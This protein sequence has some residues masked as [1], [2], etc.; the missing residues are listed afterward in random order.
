MVTPRCRV[1]MGKR[2]SMIARFERLGSADAV[3]DAIGK[4]RR[5]Q[6]VRFAIAAALIAALLCGTGVLVYTTGGTRYAYL[7][8]GYIPILFGAL[9]FGIPGAVITAVAAAIVVGPWMPLNVLQDLPQ[10][11][12]S[13]I[14]RGLFFVAFALITGLLLE[15]LNEENKAIRRMA[16]LDLHTRLPNQQ[17]L[18]ADLRQHLDRKGSASLLLTIIELGRFDQLRATFGPERLDS[19]VVQAAERL[20]GRISPGGKLYR[21]GPFQLAV[22]TPSGTTEHSDHLTTALHAPADC[23]GVPVDLEAHAGA[24]SAPEHAATAGDLIKAAAAALY[25]ARTS[26]AASVMFDPN[27]CTQQVRSFTLVSELREALQENA[28]Q[29]YYQ[30]KVGLRTGQC[31]G[32]EALLRWRHPRHGFV[33]P[34]EFVPYVEQTTL[35]NDLTY[36]AINTALRQVVRWRQAGLPFPVAV[37]LSARNLENGALPA[38]IASLLHKHGLDAGALQMEITETAIMHD[39]GRSARVLGELQAIGVGI[40]IDDFGVGQSSLTYLASL[41]VNEIKLDRALVAEVIEHRKYDR[42]VRSAIELGHHLG[43]V[44][45]AEGIETKAVADRLRNHG[46][47]MAQGY[48]FA[49]AM[50]EA[51]FEAW[52]RREAAPN[53]AATSAA[54]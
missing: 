23:D 40:A 20:Q 34:G 53:V 49:P 32:A 45:T 50:P 7:H 18:L 46:C 21:T 6:G 12:T 54:G 1:V 27:I 43:M 30:P 31:V 36:W 5:P 35:I 51:E 41:P 33:P 44:V 3:A 26:G 15:L 17:A 42:I 38:E 8:V 48:F 52:V 25:R 22:V 9:F 2:N 24:A 4:W 11:P 28:L 14:A 29:L 39:A 19:L 37:N 13:W 10:P 47:D 16:Y